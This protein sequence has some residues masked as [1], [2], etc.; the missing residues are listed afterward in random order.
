MTSLI[1]RAAARVLMPLLV[2]FAIFLLGRGHNEP[3]G[4]FVAGLVVSVAFVLRMLSD[5]PKAA[6]TALLVHPTKLIAAGLLIAL[7]SGF[8]PVALGRPFMTACWLEVGPPDSDLL[9]GTPLIF[10]VGVCSVVIG[11]VLT[12]TF[13]LAED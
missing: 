3:G 1:L 9:L 8:F 6:R 5:G 11:V 13:N 7:A 10:D 2:V 12:M 4:G